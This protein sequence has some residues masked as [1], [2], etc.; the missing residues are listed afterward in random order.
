MLDFNPTR[1]TFLAKIHSQPSLSPGY[2][3]YPFLLQK[4]IRK[5]EGK[6]GDIPLLSFHLALCPDRVHGPHDPGLVHHLCSHPDRD[7]SRERVAAL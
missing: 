6:Y 2:L 1:W 5:K 4:N 7:P 3:S